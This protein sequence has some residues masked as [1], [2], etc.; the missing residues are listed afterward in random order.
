MST[1]AGK[2]YAEVIKSTGKGKKD[3]KFPAPKMKKLKPCP[4]CGSTSVCVCYT[5][6]KKVKYWRAHCQDCDWSYGGSSRCT[7]E[8]KAIRGWNKRVGGINER[9]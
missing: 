5:E 3:R 4:G 8:K 7:S 1:T 2:R 9:K 6:Y